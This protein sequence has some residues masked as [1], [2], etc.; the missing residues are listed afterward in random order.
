MKTGKITVD[1]L[2]P[3]PVEKVW[4]LWTDPEH[5]RQWNFA[6]PDWHTPHAENDLRKEGS[7]TYRMEAKD[8]SAGFEF[9]GKY[10]EIEPHSFI[11]YTLGD[12]R[13]VSI[14]F[15]PVDNATFIEESFEPEAEN[16]RERQRDGWQAILENFRKYAEQQ[17]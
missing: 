17:T 12:G 9:T 6:T 2:V 14:H 3:L 15:K 4:H 13:E 8:G 10:D 7:F 1:T 5:I 11:R 16:S